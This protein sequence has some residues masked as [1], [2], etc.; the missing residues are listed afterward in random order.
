MPLTLNSSQ[1][2]QGPIKCF[3]LHIFMRKHFFLFRPPQEANIL[4]WI[5]LNETIFF[6]ERPTPPPHPPTPII[7]WSM[8]NKSYTCPKTTNTKKPLFQ[9]S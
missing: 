1:L 2:S 7:L 8:T 9:T 6:K 4:V 3:L 5:Y